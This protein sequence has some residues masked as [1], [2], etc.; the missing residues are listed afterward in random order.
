MV[1][2]RS[3]EL[4]AQSLHMMEEGQEESVWSPL[5]GQMQVDGVGFVRWVHDVLES[6]TFRPSPPSGRVDV[7]ITLPWPGLFCVPFK[8]S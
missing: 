2:R 7:V 4:V 3:G 5:L 8:P 6:T 1:S